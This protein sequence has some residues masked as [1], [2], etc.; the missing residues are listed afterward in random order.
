MVDLKDKS[1][2][3]VVPFIKKQERDIYFDCIAEALATIPY[4]YADKFI[5]KFRVVY[6]EKIN[7]QHN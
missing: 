1:I 7:G 3:V 2:E 6:E 4:K 5:T